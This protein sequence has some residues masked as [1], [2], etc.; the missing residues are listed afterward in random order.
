MNSLFPCFLRR[1][2]RFF[3]TNWIVVGASLT[4]PL[5]FVF[6]LYAYGAQTQL[7][8]AI[9]SQTLSGEALEAKI[10][11]LDTLT[12]VSLLSILGM[13]IAFA[14]VGFFTDTRVKS[15]Y[16]AFL[17]TLDFQEL[18][19][20]AEGLETDQESRQFLIQELTRRQPGWSY[21]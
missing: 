12:M 21:A 9:A 14:I 8:D 15:R 4:F 18:K 7:I 13:F 1:Q 11:A 16:Q 20:L 6:G 2:S 19:R 10:A 5:L 3:R 17:T